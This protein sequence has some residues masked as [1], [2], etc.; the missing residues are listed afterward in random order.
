MAVLY[1]E[2]NE[3]LS[4]NVCA[5]NQWGQA[6]QRALM[7]NVCITFSCPKA[8]YLTGYKYS[9][10]MNYTFIVYCQIMQNIVDLI[11]Y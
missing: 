11:T 7:A 4:F 3:T 5:G 6:T 10:K 2:Y 9:H 1:P 8:L